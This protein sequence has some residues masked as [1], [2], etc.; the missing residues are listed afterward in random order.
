[1]NTLIN[2]KNRWLISLLMV[3]ALSFIVLISCDSDD[4]GMPVESQVTLNLEYAE[5]GVFKSLELK[6]KFGSVTLPQKDYTWS[7]SD[8]NILKVEFDEK[9]YIATVTAL[10]EGEATAT[11]RSSDGNLQASCAFH[12]NLIKETEVT[13]PES[14]TAFTQSDVVVNPEFNNVEKPIRSYSW[15]SNPEGIV[16]VTMDETTA[17]ATIR[18]LSPG[19]TT[20]TLS[21]ADGAVTSSIQVTVLDENDGILKI[22][23]IGN[24]FSDDALLS[25]LYGLADAAGKEIV[26]G[27]M[28]IGGAELQQH[29]DN[30]A[31]DA[32]SYQYRKIDQ[33]GMY[34]NTSSVALSTAIA[35]ENWDYISFQQASPKS[36]QYDSFE[37]PL[38]ELYSWVNNKV[39]NEY[40]KYILHQT[41]AYA[42]NST[43]SGF[44]N[45][46]N[47]QMTMYNA[48]V[49]AYNQAKT[50]IPTYMVIPAG[51][52]IQNARTSYVEDNFTRDGYHLNEHGKFTASCVW[53]QKLFG[54]SVLGN[55]YMPS[56][57]AQYDI[58]LSQ[59]AADY[60]VSSPNQVTSLT[61]FQTAEGSG[62]ITGPVKINFATSSST[63]GW[64]GMTS[65][66]AGSA[67][68]NLKYEDNTFTGVKAKLL[69]RFNGQNTGGV[70]ETTTSLNMPEE[71]SKYSFYGNYNSP[72]GGIIVEKGVIEFSGF[73]S[74]DMYEFCFFGSRNGVGDNRE[75][76]YI[77]S[78]STTQ[79][80]LL[81]PSNNATEIACVSNIQPDA[82]GKITVT[83][84]IGPNN[85]NGV[86]F[87]YINAMQITPQ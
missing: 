50:L 83:V 63:N 44:E 71:V 42:Q 61:D 85:T 51:T 78:G 36:G 56:G 11:I 23:A 18:G 4:D 1:M 24:S 69:E 74:T 21:S 82:D 59:A 81:N 12:T 9:S 6:P 14:L 30:T 58:D 27:V 8:E 79:E 52:G 68:P 86:G 7:V 46:N 28:Y 26:I 75:T 39:T 45:Y 2:N 65:Y 53:F 84:T 31:S 35:D 17:A 87:F 15:T 41:W 49:D 80:A 22:L 10:A 72:W 43:H 47:D 5:L 33:N 29:V 40:T 70:S 48:I 64:N 20:L 25:H 76:K 77:V 55:T 66:L 38:P 57:F 16:S 54:E 32:A 19:T 60:A 67:I 34:T 3:F 37:G 13:L 62:I 73:T